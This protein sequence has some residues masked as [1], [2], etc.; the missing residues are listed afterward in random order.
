VIEAHLLV[1][2]VGLAAGRLSVNA[3]P[4]SPQ[5]ATRPKQG[6]KPTSKPN[7]RTP[8]TSRGYADAV[9]GPIRLKRHQAHFDSKLFA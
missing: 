6:Y 4:V 8:A 2:S 5:A 3:K 7:A 9:I 1:P